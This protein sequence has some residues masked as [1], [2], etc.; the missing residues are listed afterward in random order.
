[1][2][3]SWDEVHDEAEHLEHAVTDRLIDRIDEMLGRPETDPHG[4]PIPNAEGLGEA[5]GARR[6]CLSCPLETDRHRDARDRSGQRVPA[7]HRAASSQAGRGDR[8]SK[9]G[10]PPPT[11]CASAARTISASR[12]ARAPRRSCW[13]RS[14]RCCCSACWRCRRSRRPTRRHARR[15]PPRTNLSG[16]MDFHFNKPEFADGRLDFHRFVLLVTHTFSPRIRFVGELELE[17]AFVEGL[18]EARRARAGTG[19]RRLPARR[20]RSTSAPA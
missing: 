5:A 1:M 9:R 18:E 7:L 6:R 15:A 20:D 12:S 13:C 16:Y 14:R 2:G 10:T 4:D 8:R 3:Y 11:A 19:L 17:H